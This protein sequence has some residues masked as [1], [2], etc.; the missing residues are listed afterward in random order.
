MILQEG[1]KCSFLSVY[2]PECRKR[3]FYHNMREV[4]FNS[5]GKLCGIVIL[6]SSSVNN[7]CVCLP[8]L[9]RLC[10]IS[11]S[12]LL[13]RFLCMQSFNHSLKWHGVRHVS[14]LSHKQSLTS[15]EHRCLS[16]SC[17]WPLFCCHGFVPPQTNIPRALPLTSATVTWQLHQ[18]YIVL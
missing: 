1:I 2:F 10:N 5:D 3:H 16:T 12:L 8:A 6:V 17:L 13:F 14:T 9:L 15:T 4:N 7:T 11:S 18:F